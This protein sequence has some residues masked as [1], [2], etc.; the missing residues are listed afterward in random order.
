MYRVDNV[1]SFS[2]PTLFHLS[3]LLPESH[4]LLKAELKP[5]RKLTFLSFFFLKNQGKRNHKS[6]RK[7]P[8]CNR[9]RCTLKGTSGPLQSPHFL[10]KSLN[11]TQVVPCSKSLGLCVAEQRQVA[12]SGS[13]GRMHTQVS[14]A[15]GERERTLVFSVVGGLLRAE[16][17]PVHG[18]I[19][20]Q[21]TARQTQD[22]SCWSNMG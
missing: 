20:V 9:S 21:R 10:V 11:P 5:T 14:R 17:D 18:C 12:D 4:N 2:Q 16:G 22:H 13:S 15:P 8:K 7:S 19:L 1:I 3:T 6:T